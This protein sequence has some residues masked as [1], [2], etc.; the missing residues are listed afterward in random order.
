V[1]IE[2]DFSALLREAEAVP[3]PPPSIDF[4]PPEDGTSAGI[5]DPS[6]SARQAGPAPA[7]PTPPG[8]SP[9]PQPGLPGESGIDDTSA[10]AGQVA[11]ALERLA[12]QSGQ[13]LG[14]HQIPPPEHSDLS[15]DITGWV[16]MAGRGA[17]KTYAGSRWMHAHCSK[18]PGTRA[19][20]IAPS[21]ADA[22]ASCI[23]GPSGILAASGHQVVWKPSHPGG[24]QLV[25][26]NGS[27]CY[28]IG[29]PTP[30][31][32]DRLRALTN[33]D[34]DWFE[35]AAANTQL[36][37]VER[38]ARLS[39]RNKGARRWIATTTP[40]PIKTIREWKKDPHVSVTTAT[41]HS[42]RHAD[43]QW[44]EELER[45]YRGTRLYR[46]EVLGEVLEDV[47]GALWSAD[48]LDR[49]RIQDLA[50]FYEML[51]ATGRTVTRAAVGV[52][53]AN[54]TG[55][56]GI[57]S[58]LTT[59]DR[60]LYVVRDSSMP[61]RSAEQWARVAV[62]DASGY[63][64]VLVPENDSG[65]D[66]IRAVLKAADLLD[67]V[68]IMPATA[69]GRGGKGTRAEPIAL[70]WEREDFRGHLVGSFPLLEDQLTTFVPD[71]PGQDSPDR[72]DAMVW[73]C[74]YLWSRASFSD[75]T[76]SWPNSAYGQPGAVQLRRP[77]EVL[78]WRSKSKAARHRKES[79][80]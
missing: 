28:V 21:F 65:G 3:L 66:A 40:R 68:T 58:V 55:T 76:S 49:S 24:A 47:E 34:I 67:E 50:A 15:T 61:G 56:T 2:V 41:A 32:V 59:D 39:R 6:P 43:P 20:I 37:E 33:C 25:W 10:F 26:P 44:L 31:E 64:A 72:L 70:L 52:D 60:H 42:N 54:S 4:P 35:E 53:P 78:P 46:Q 74:T 73:A 16:M 18:Y 8:Q 23:E 27:V 14:P 51:A 5:P 7:P 48:D 45:M 63:N 80:G 11:V 22:V 79:A 30:R 69:R 62:D 38:Q 17:G 36:V 71:A 75:V 1:T 29:T 77:G 19:R 12:P 13:E 9:L 57:V